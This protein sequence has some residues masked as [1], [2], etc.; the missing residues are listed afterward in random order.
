[1]TYFKKL[2]LFTTA[3]LLI[4]MLFISC[5]ENE[6]DI[7]SSE[8]YVVDVYAAEYAF[9][10]PSEIKSGW[11]TFRFD[12]KGKE[13]HVAQIYHLEG[14]ISFDE[15][16]SILSAEP[17]QRVPHESVMGGPG[18]HTTGESS[19]ITIKLE[20]GSYEILCG[21]VTE[22]GEPHA[23]R[24]MRKYFVVTD[25]VGADQP[26]KPDMR[27]ALDE[28]RLT[29]DGELQGGSQTVEIDGHHTD[30]DLHL[31][32]LEGASTVD[33]A[34]DYF[35]DLRDPT[36][37]KILGGVEEGHTSYLTL[38]ITPGDYIWSS[39]EYGHFGMYEKF[40]ISPEGKQILKG[41]ASGDTEQIDVRVKE[42]AIEA[43]GELFSGNKKVA[44]HTD[45][46]QTHQLRFAR[47]KEGFTQEDYLKIMQERQDGVSNND[48]WPFKGYLIN[49]DPIT[50]DNSES[51]TLRLESGNYLLYCAE[52]DQ[53]GVPHRLSG[54]MKSI[55]VK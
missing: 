24:G 48:E 22:E 20:P 7:S 55:S 38:D 52:D 42:N 16:R 49:V 35:S 23:Y 11:V 9:G 46:S 36:R 31:V 50:A 44:F 45:D 13:T 5:G 53:E 30:F 25:E 43:P 4:S 6:A 34:F 19:E 40:A 29:I 54:E 37:A 51:F 21:L 3:L 8:S 17:R 33:E 47:L 28:Y 18:L 14:D 39:Q 32:T 27:I 12:N 1:M 10:M 26:P 15:Y 41:D 2:S